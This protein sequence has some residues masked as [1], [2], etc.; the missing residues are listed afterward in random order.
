MVDRR[1]VVDPIWLEEIERTFGS[2]QL[3]AMPPTGERGMVC[4]MEV[5]EN[6]RPYLRRL[7][8]P[9]NGAIR[10]ALRPLRCHPPTVTL[11][12]RWHAEHRGW[13]PSITKPFQATFPLGHVVVTPGALQALA[14]AGLLPMEFVRRHQSGDW[15]EISEED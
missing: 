1:T 11:A 5:A 15:G 13:V 9:L 7:V 2:Y 6:S 4:Q 14:Q 3:T 12:V 8:H 10:D